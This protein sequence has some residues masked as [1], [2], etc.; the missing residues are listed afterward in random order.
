MPLD[1]FVSCDTVGVA[2]PA[3]A[4][5]RSVLA[6]FAPEDDKWFA[7]AHMWDVS[8]A[9]RAGFRGAYCTIYE[10]ESC[11]EIFGAKMEVVADLLPD[12]ARAIIKT[13]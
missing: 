5:Y 9:V 10:K 6:K 8:A 7:A 4:A 13:P 11:E 1:N 3:L 2:K 12:M